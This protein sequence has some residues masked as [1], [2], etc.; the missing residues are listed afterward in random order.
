M[1][2]CLACSQRFEANNWRC[3]ECGKS[4]PLNNGYLSFLPDM[5]ETN[6]GFSAVYFAQ[7]ATVEESSFWFR[8]RN[9]LLIW[10]LRRY[11]PHINKF[12]EIGCGTGLVLSGIQRYFPGLKLSGSEIF[13][14]G[15]DFAKERLP[16]V[17]LFQM[18]AR[19]IPFEDE[20]DVIGAFDVL[21]H[22]DEDELVLLQMFRA[23]RRAGGIILTVPQHRFLWSGVDE[24]SFHKRRYTR[25]DLVGKVERAGFRIIRVTSFVSFLLPLMI[26]SRLKQCRPQRDFDPLREY[27]IG[28]LLN[29]TF[30]NVLTIE[31][32]LIKSGISFPAGGSLLVVAK[33]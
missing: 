1:K 17:N 7:L 13:S 15:L 25:R 4:P 8:S 5:T 29:M 21:E 20:F 22:I 32:G 23:I 10:A 27:K 26:F 16:D 12:L 28:T 33:K 14:E 9:N 24:Y 6:D 11:F 19:R 3:P 30:E 18:D 2:V 31:R